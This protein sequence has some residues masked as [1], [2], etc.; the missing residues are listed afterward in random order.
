MSEIN[1]LLERANRIVQCQNDKLKESEVILNEK[2]AIYDD[3]AAKLTEERTKLNGLDQ[4][5]ES[6]KTAKEKRKTT[7]RLA[8]ILTSTIISILSAIM[9]RN[10]HTIKLDEFKTLLSTYYTIDVIAIGVAFV[11]SKI[12]NRKPKKIISEF[13]KSNDLIDYEDVKERVD[14]LE[15]QLALALDDMNLSQTNYDL[16]EGEVSLLIASLNDMF[17]EVSGGTEQFI[18]QIEPE[19]TDDIRGAYTNKGES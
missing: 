3:I 10:I 19:I 13:C 7:N 8:V 1:L 11:I 18:E 4:Q 12:I 17:Y 14:K 6:F 9:F 5:I 2:K 16:I 15:K